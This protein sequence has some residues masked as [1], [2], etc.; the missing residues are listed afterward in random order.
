[1][2]LCL[3]DTVNNLLPQSGA[4]HARQRFDLRIEFV[5]GQADEFFFEPQPHDAMHGA[6]QGL[7][8]PEM[9]RRVKVGTQDAQRRENVPEQSHLIAERPIGNGPPERHAMLEQSAP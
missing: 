5:W 2:K 6:E 4:D 3:S 8:Q 9:R 7:R 1:M